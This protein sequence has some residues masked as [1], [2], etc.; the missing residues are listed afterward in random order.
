MPCRDDISRV[1]RAIH[2]AAITS[3]I[4]TRPKA[5]RIVDDWHAPREPQLIARVAVLGESH[6]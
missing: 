5:E 2:P 3:A 1:R 6:F 4:E